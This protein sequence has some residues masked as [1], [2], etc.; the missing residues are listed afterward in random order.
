MA[1]FRLFRPMKFSNLEELITGDE[2]EILC[3]MAFCHLERYLQGINLEYTTHYFS[4]ELLRLLPSMKKLN[5]VVIRKKNKD[6]N[7]S[8]FHLLEVCPDLSYIDISTELYTRA[9]HYEE[10]T[11]FNEIMCQK[12]FFT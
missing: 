11:V 3:R 8:L 1:A 5:R 12:R 4:D 9:N 6:T 10:T 7:F 2:C